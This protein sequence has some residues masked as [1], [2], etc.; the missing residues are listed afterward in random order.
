MR[1]VPTLLERLARHG[2]RPGSVAMDKGYDFHATYE[3]CERRGA[4]AVV[5]KRKNSGTGDGPITRKGERFKRLYRARASVEREFGRL[6]HQLSLAPLRMRGIERVQLHA[7]L[8]V[9]TRLVVA[10]QNA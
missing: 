1:G 3:E 8:C 2:V 10:L 7:D 9:L 6:K 4:L 5:S